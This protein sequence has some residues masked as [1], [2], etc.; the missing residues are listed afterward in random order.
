MIIDFEDERNFAREIPRRGLDKS[1]R[2]GI[3]VA[4]RLNGQFE[5]VARIV[6]RRVDGE[7]A[8]R[9]VFEALVHRQ[10]DQSAGA[11]QFAVVQESGQVG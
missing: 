3:S 11:A 2:R 7:A 1:Q 4:A 10:N 5:M 9:A 6:A 8:G